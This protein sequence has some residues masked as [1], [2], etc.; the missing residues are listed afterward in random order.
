M[1][2]CQNAAST[3]PR[4]VSFSL[5]AVA[6]SACRRSVPTC[7]SKASM[8]QSG[9]SQSSRAPP[10]RV[11]SATMVRSS[12]PLLSILASLVRSCSSGHE[13]KP[14]GGGWPSASY[15]A[16]SSP[17]ASTRAVRVALSLLSVSM[18]IVASWWAADESSSCARRGSTW[19]TSRACRSRT[20]ASAC[21]RPRRPRRLDWASTRRVPHVAASAASSLSSAALARRTANVRTPTAIAPAATGRRMRLMSVAATPSTGRVGDPGSTSP[22]SSSGGGGVVVASGSGWP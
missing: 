9:I 17:H 12:A 2:R 15:S 14:G 16:R 21:C 5:R 11:F 18:L 1:L 10:S 8:L 4:I 7:S 3:L 13:R 20:P 19:L 22:S 6:S